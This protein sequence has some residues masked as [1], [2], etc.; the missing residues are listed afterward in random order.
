ML[1]QE[2]IFGLKYKNRSYSTSASTTRQWGTD[3]KQ[4]IALGWN[5]DSLK[6]KLADDFAGTNQQADA[7]RSSVLPPSEVNS[8]PYI[9]YSFFEPR[10]KTRTNV[11]TYDLAEDLR[12]GAS[13]DIS[14]GLGLKAFGSTSTFQRGGVS[15]GYTLGWA[16]DGSATLSAAY[17]TRYQDGEARDNTA[18]STLRVVTP[19]LGIWGRLVSDMTVATRWN[20]RVTRFYFLGSD[21]G[22]RGF[23]INQ[24]FGKRLA[25]EQLE[26]RST[27]VPIWVFRAG[28][29]LFYEAGGAGDTADEVK[30]FHDV[31][32]GVRAL[33][34]QTSRELFRFDLAFPLNGPTPGH[35]HFIA[36]FQS[37]F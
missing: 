30:L 31:G 20:D 14:Y 36:G 28:G 1:P 37:D 5:V 16:A 23:D 25:S 13:F 35:P 18:S 4:Q 3:L 7:F 32:F 17:A 29:V 19:V 11:Q 9:E 2:D 24:F 34:P 22:L 15:A 21:N 26:L 12:I 6:Y 33:V 8:A 27:P 10:Y